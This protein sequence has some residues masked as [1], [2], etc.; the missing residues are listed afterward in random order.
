VTAVGGDVVFTD[1]SFNVTGTKTILFTATNLTSVTSDPIVVGAG[2]ASRL[3]FTQ[4]PGLTASGAPFGVQPIVKS[5]DQFGNDSTTGLP[6]SQNVTMSIST[7]TGPLL[8]AISQNI[9]TNFGRGVAT[10]TNLEIDAAGTK[11]LTASSPGLGALS[12]TLH[13]RWA[14]PASGSRRPLT[15]APGTAMGRKDADAADSGHAFTVTVNAVVPVTT[16]RINNDRLGSL[17]DGT[18]PPQTRRW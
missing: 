16:R 8:G 6:A 10:Y 11:Q 13:R 4:Q 15:F 12:T 14:S 7:G 18:V 3:V 17:L 1:L 2:P 9:G 5:Q